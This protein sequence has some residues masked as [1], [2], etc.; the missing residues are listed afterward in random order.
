M[1]QTLT[2][3]QYAIMTTYRDQFI[4]G[5]ERGL[6][7]LKDQVTTDFV[8]EG[9]SYVML[10]ADSGS[11]TATT[12]GLNG[13][14]PARVN[15][16]N[17]YTITLEQWHDL[18]QMQ[19]FNI[20]QSQG[21]QVAIAQQ[22]SMK[23]IGRKVDDLILTA[24]D[25]TTTGVDTVTSTDVLGLTR[26]AQVILGRGNFATDDGNVT[27]VVSPSFF[28][29]LRTT[30][31]FS[32]AE[33]VNR[34]AMQEGIPN[35]KQLWNWLGTYFLVHNGISGVGTASEKCFMF[36]R[37]AIGFAMD[38][39]T[40]DVEVGYNGEQDYSYARCSG[41]FGAKLLQNAGVVEMLHDGSAFA[42]ASV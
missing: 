12:R 9:S 2:G 29:R 15:N 23:V 16:N 8:K 10:V 17:Q 31:E 33:W 13:N 37:D 3:N 7:V 25:T 40:L 6:S 38:N 5:A 19:R 26:A 34:K 4:A 18:V 42:A 35:Q 28:A 20:F 30:K 36:H 22:T 14:I 27:A 1:G 24:M 11:A 21:P 39:G 32:H 41:F